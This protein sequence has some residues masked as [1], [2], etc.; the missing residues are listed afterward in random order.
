MDDISIKIQNQRVLPNTK[1]IVAETGMR[2]HNSISSRRWR[3]KGP[4][5][6]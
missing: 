5:E 2:I 3:R 1:S 6:S 4:I